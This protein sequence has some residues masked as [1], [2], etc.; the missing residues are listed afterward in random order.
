MRELT[1]LLTSSCLDVL[2]VID[3]I[4]SVLNKRNSALSLVTF[5]SFAF[6]YRHV[7]MMMSAVK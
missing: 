2:D 3:R 7:M 1:G 6:V 5:A 4:H